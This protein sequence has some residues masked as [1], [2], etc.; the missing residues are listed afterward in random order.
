MLHKE[1]F[2]TSIN[3]ITKHA[4]HPY[5]LDL[6]QWRCD[7]RTVAHILVNKPWRKTLV[8]QVPKLHKV[9]QS[10]KHAQVLGIDCISQIEKNGFNNDS[11][12]RKIDTR[13]LD[14]NRVFAKL[15]FLPQWDLSQRL[16]PQGI[17]LSFIS[18]GQING[19][20]SITRQYWQKGAKTVSS[21]VS[22]TLPTDRQFD[23]VYYV[24]IQ[25]LSYST[26]NLVGAPDKCNSMY[27]CNF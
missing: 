1:E 15:I 17:Y 11:A 27:T 21:S 18:I 14:F 5:H 8:N 16:F 23:M 25:S 9:N 22:F 6:Y 24:Y 2:S 4:N 20:T 3:Q 13:F 26:N 7:N 19:L 10:A 12:A